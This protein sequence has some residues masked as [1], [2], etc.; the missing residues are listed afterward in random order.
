[1]ANKYC[2]YCGSNQTETKF[3]DEH[4]INN[5]IGG[6]ETFKICMKHNTFFLIKTLVVLIKLLQ[7]HLKQ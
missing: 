3:N 5:S 7:R 6:H 4:I 2:I 1:M